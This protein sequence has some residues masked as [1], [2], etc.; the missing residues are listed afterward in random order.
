MIKLHD[1]TNLLEKSWISILSATDSQGPA[2]A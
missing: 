2:W 1:Q